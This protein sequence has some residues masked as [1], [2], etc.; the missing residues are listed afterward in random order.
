MKFRLFKKNKDK[1]VSKP[2]LR[3]PI[4]VLGKEKSDKEWADKLL[5]IGLI[6]HFLTSCKKV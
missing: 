5:L 3:T 6:M 4:S 2:K 1:V